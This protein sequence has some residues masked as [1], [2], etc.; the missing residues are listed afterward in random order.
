[1]DRDTQ[2]ELQQ[3][4]LRNVRALLDKE[5]EELARQKRAPRLLLYAFIPAIV[6]IAAVVIWA[7][8]RK[9]GAPDRKMLECTMRTWAEMSGAREREI[10]A[11]N[12]GIGSS[13]VGRT[14]QAENSAIEAAAAAQC[15][16]ELR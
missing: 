5:E 11:Q 4:S 7:S 8:G 6:L 3:R 9:S 15:R 2:Q 12:P 10:R 16:K 14:L 13:E 1:M